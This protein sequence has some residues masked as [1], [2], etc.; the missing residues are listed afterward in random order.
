[1]SDQFRVFAG[2]CTTVFEGARDRTQRGRV[3]VLV[4]PDRTVLVHDADGYQP[5][6]WLTRPDTLTVESDVPPDLLAEGPNGAGADSRGDGPSAG[7]FG[8]TARAGDQTL[9]VV[10]HRTFGTARYPA[11]AAGVPVGRCPDCAG[12]LVRTAGDVACLD[13]DVRHPVPAGAA[14][15]DATCD[16]CGFPRLRVESGVTGDDERC[17][18]PGCGTEAD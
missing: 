5:V 3:V 4:K 12:A 6:A 11:G 7:G 18:S 16:D 1:M 15:L 13:C 2:D 14:V 10:S 9:R 8:L 17:L